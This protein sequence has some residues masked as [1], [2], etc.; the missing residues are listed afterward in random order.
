MRGRAIGVITAALALCGAAALAEGAAGGTAEGTAGGF[1]F[2]SVRPP[3]GSGPRITVQITEPLP[4]PRKKREPERATVDGSAGFW[5]VISP[6]RAAEERGGDRLALASEVLATAP[7][8]PPLPPLG[9]MRGIAARHGAEIARATERHRVSP[10]LVLAVIAVESAGRPDAVSKV[11]ATGLMQL[12]PATARRFGVADA[13]Q[14]AQNV[15]GGIAYLDWLL[16]RFGGD[17]ILA[18]AAYNAGEGAVDRHSGVPPYAETRAYVPKV[19]AAWRVARTLCA[20]PPDTP[21]APCTLLA[22]S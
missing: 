10:A 8:A 6:D 15:Q 2:R 9:L 3:T 17:P 20:A 12:M 21:R 22:A 1:T 13:L 16:A 18:I 4:L 7:D 5:A 19:I 11:G 14:P